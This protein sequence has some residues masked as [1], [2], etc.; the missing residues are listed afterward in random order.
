VLDLR[1]STTA[2]KVVVTCDPTRIDG[3]Q[4]L[5]RQ[6]HTA[7]SLSNVE[8]ELELDDFLVN[9]RELAFWPK[10]DLD[11][12]W[13]PELLRLVESNARDANVLQT[14]LSEDEQSVAEVDFSTNKEWNAPLTEFQK[15]NIGKLAQHGACG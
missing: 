8:F 13:Q 4:T 6:F 15:R 7:T 11:T 2:G 1:F 12:K 10:T 5:R 3:L 14:K 9:L